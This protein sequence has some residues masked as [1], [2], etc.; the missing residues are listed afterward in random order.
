[1]VGDEAV[2]FEERRRRIR[3]T[4]TC[5]DLWASLAKQLSL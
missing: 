1:M 2:K 3:R 4:T 5:S